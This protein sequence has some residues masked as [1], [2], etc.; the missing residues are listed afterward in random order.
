MAII[1]CL[2]QDGC[3]GNHFYFCG[4]AYSL[5]AEINQVGIKFLWPPDGGMQGD[6]PLDWMTGGNALLKISGHGDLLFVKNPVSP[7]GLFMAIHGGYVQIGRERVATASFGI[8]AL[9]GKRPKRSN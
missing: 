3:A 6:W 1:R 4:K 8:M 2:E 9:S 5:F 7:S